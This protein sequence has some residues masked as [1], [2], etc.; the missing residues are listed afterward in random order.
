MNFLFLSSDLDLDVDALIHNLNQCGEYHCHRISGE[1][2]MQSEYRCNWDLNHSHERLE[3]NS[4]LISP[5][6]FRASYIFCRDIGFIRNC[7]SPKV[8]FAQEESWSF[9]EGFM[10]C[11]PRWQWHDYY[12]DQLYWDNK[13]IQY[14][15]SKEL[16]IPFPST[17]VAND[18]K[19]AVNFVKNR[20]SIIKQMS[21]VAFTNPEQPESPSALFTSRIE[22]EDIDEA[23]IK[24]CPVLLQEFIPKNADIRYYYVAGNH[25]AARIDSQVHEDSEVDFRKK[26]DAPTAPFDPPPKLKAYVDQISQATGLRYSAFDF[27]ELKN[28]EFVFFEFNPIGNWLWIEQITELP[29]SKA[30]ADSLKGLKI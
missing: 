15:L 19:A 30:I 22:A 25:F 24:A 3:F 14:R 8:R 5:E 4:D 9:F 28:G 13:I 23:S 21:D 2:V 12:Y 17:L 29:I 27:A 6:E 10:K 20:P 18:H 26:P 16:G 7:D 11:M 1:E